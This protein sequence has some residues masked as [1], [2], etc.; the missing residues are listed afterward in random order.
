[1]P[2]LQFHNLEMYYEQMGTG[3]PVLFL[4]SGFSRGILAFASQI[5]DFQRKYTCY[6]P[7][8]RGHGRTQS[9]SLEWSTPRHVEDIIEFMDQL[10]ISNAHVIGYGM[11]GGVALHCAVSHPHRIASLTSIGQCGF[12]ASKR[13]EEFEPEWLLQN[14]HNDFINSM[15]ERH[16]DAH[17]GN[18]QEFLRQKVK[19]WRTYPRLNDEELSSIACPILFIAGQ[20]DELAPEDDLKRS[21]ALIHNSRYVI[22]PGSS[23]RPHMNGENP[24]FVNDTILNFIETQHS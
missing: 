12:V 21:A 4:H 7:D 19:D 14:G 20:Y 6:F 2:Y 18:W 3:D 16:M 15:I 1:M 13:S 10:H 8:F 17:Q 9:Y 22:V 23:H 24:V 11:G 5:L